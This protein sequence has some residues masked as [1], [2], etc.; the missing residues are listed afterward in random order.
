MA[1]IGP[2]S[3]TLSAARMALG[4]RDKNRHEAIS[5]RTARTSGGTNRSAMLN[6]V[7][8]IPSTST[9]SMKS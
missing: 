4:S 6:A 7:A 9:E 1:E 8:S 3:S 2:T 5:Q